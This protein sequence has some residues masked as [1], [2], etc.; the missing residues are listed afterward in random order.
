MSKHGALISFLVYNRHIL[1]CEEVQTIEVLSVGLEEEVGL[2]LLDLHNGLEHDA[3]AVLNELTERVEVCGESSRGGEN[4]LLILTFALAEELLEPFVHHNEV[5][6]VAYEH[7]NAL[8]LIIK[9]ITER[10]ILIT[11]I[12]VVLRILFSACGGAGH[13]L[14]D[15]DACNCDRQQ[16][17]CGEH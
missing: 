9:D 2:R 17:Y 1:I 10:G 11:V 13:E 15:V 4:T 7:L 6:V 5:G 14:V 16:T 3:R 8:A 12:S